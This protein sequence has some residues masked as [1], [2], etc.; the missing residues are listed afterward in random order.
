MTSKRSKFKSKYPDFSVLPY[1][2]ML[3]A[4]LLVGMFSFYP[5]VKTVINTFSVTNMIGEWQGWA[6]LFHWKM[7]FDDEVFRISLRNTFK[8]AGVVLVTS[9]VSAM[10]LALIGAKRGKGQRLITTLY[11]LP[12]AISSSAAAI[13]WTMF[14]APALRGGFLNG[15]LGTDIYWLGNVKTAFWC[16]AFSTVW[17]HIPSCY[18]YLLAG[19]RNVSDELLEAATLDGANAFVKATRIQI[20]MASPQIFFVLFLSIVSSLRVFSQINLL[21][22]GGPAYTTANLTYEIYQKAMG[23]AMYSQA[24]CYSI[25]LFVIIFVI[26]RIQFIFEKKLVFYQ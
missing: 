22:A 26:T 13:L 16:V 17:G 3:P 8:Y 24:C 23:E 19:F 11:A 9:F 25:V 21:T 1:F 10:L 15:I 18:L 20:P 4:V 12:M 2:W 14:F 7:L 6:G 5:F